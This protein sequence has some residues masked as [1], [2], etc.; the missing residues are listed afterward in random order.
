MGATI[1]IQERVLPADGCP[2]LLISQM[3]A[4]LP[5]VGRSFSFGKIFSE[6]IAYG[7]ACQAKPQHTDQIQNTHVYALLSTDFRLTDLYMIGES[8]SL[9][10]GTTAYRSR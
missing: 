8:Q 3:T 5:R 4:K 2:E 10:R 9:R 7:K 1:I 6:G